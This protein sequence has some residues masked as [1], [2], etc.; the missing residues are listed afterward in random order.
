M[1]MIMA[2]SALVQQAHEGVT[3]VEK[4]QINYAIYT[5]YN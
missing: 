4:T 5:V 3:I 1:V 2:V